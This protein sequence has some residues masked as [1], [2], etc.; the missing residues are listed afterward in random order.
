MNT[1]YPGAGEARKAI[2][3]HSRLKRG[4]PSMALCSKEKGPSHQCPPHHIMG[5]MKKM[6]IKTNCDPFTT[7]DYW[8]SL[9][10]NF[11][12]HKNL[13]IS[14]QQC[15]TRSLKVISNMEKVCQTWSKLKSFKQQAK[16]YS[17]VQ[18]EF[19]VRKGYEL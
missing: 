11:A 1:E 16:N 10:Q 8:L 2:L 6:L 13:S 3:T 12:F 18:G 7:A 4:E 5:P 14:K 17:Q 9:P 15:V 19:H